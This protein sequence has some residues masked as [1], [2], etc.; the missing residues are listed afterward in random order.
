MKSLGFDGVTQKEMKMVL[1][2]FGHLIIQEPVNNNSVTPAVETPLTYDEI[3]IKLRDNEVQMAGMKATLN[4]LQQA[5]AK[6]QNEVQDLKHL[7]QEERERT[8]T[9]LKS[10]TDLEFELAKYHESVGES[11]E[12]RGSST[13]Q[14]LENSMKKSLEEVN[15]KLQAEQQRVRSL[16]DQLQSVIDEKDHLANQNHQ[17][18]ELLRQQETSP[19]Q[20]Q[21]SNAPIIPNPSLPHPS[22]L[23][24][25]PPPPSLSV[26]AP[27]P[28]PPP[29]GLAIPNSNHGGGSGGHGGG[30][31]GGGGGVLGALGSVQLKKT[32][33]VERAP[34]VDPKSD[35]LSA[36]RGGATLKHVV[37][38][39]FSFI[40][41][42]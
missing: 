34:Y 33:V 17:M 18:Q 41:I 26:N 27:P 36:I 31:G 21:I 30:H 37:R 3:V 8:Q 9:L 6:F 40:I 29:S 15:Q 4:T 5:K 23:P 28:P 35:L 7:L 22:T 25:P 12:L 16:Q 11:N 1:K 39:P 42:F 10:N 24:P 13:L 20:P 32:E 2:K 19:S 14:N 38:F